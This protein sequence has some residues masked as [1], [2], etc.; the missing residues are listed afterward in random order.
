MLLLECKADETVV[1][2]LGRVRQNCRH[3]D[4]KGEVCNWLKKGKAPLAMIDEDPASAQPPYLSRLKLI[5]HLHGIREMR[6]EA[7][8]H[9]V[10]IVQPRLEE[11]LIASAK[12]AKLRMIDFGLSDRGN[13]LHKEINSKLEAVTRLVRMLEQTGSLRIAHLRK[14]LQS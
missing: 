11:W 3:L 8:T 13:E 2:C 10:L 12:E 7:V 1:K 5:S 4:D 9:R 6:D 14:L